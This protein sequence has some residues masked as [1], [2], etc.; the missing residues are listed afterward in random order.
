MAEFG[1]LPERVRLPDGRT[2]PF[3]PE[4]ITRSLF[5]AGERVGQPDAFLSQEMT[6]GVL[7]FLA[8]ESVGAGD[9]A[10]RASPKSSARWS[11][12]SVSR[13]SPGP[14]RSGRPRPGIPASARPRTGPPGLADRVPVGSSK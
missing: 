10:R 3:E 7:Y 1:D 12:S 9:H 2:E 5:A 4:R 13:R 11:A 14:T 6:E 8:A